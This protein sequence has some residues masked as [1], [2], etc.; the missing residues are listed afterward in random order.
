MSGLSVL[1]ENENDNIT[2]TVWRREYVTIIPKGLNPE[3]LGQCR[4][5]S[6]TN[7]FS[8]VLESY[9]LQWAWSQ[10]GE[11]MRPNQYGGLKG[12]GTDHFL[13]HLWTNLLEN[14]EDSRACAS[15]IS[16]DFSKAFNR[17]D[18]HH[19]LQSYARLG[20]S[21]EV[22]SLFAAFLSGRVL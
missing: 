14:L 5:T 17:L 15:L 12:C 10:I 22:I 3:S 19:V 6:Y 13:A 18:H 20:A 9:M 11:N 2:D 4:N 21:S 1:H 16:L 8:K 7:V